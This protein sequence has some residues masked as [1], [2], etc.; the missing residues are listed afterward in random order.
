MLK[1]GVPLVQISRFVTRPYACSYL[2]RET[3]QLDYRIIAAIS[4]SAYADLLARGWRRFGM[5]F[6]RPVC[7]ACSE[8]RSLRVRVQDFHPSE[9]QRRNF[10]RNARFQTVVQPPTFTPEHLRLYN[11][12]RADMHLR[13][14]WP[15]DPMTEAEY[16]R[17]FIE[18][19]GDFAREFLLFDGR[20][21]VGVGLAD[22]VP[23]AIS[24]ITFFHDPEYRRNALGVLSL[25]RQLEFAQ[26]N[27]LAHHYL[28]YWIAGCQSMAYKSQYRPHEILA[29]YPDANDEPVWMGDHP[30]EP[31]GRT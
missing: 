23:G 20:N 28:G 17:T 25:L 29:A 18:N 24:S 5:S 15:T 13:R 30:A 27:G 3:A 12:Y 8:C 11:T 2:P 7:V 4:S 31:A 1:R 10:R 14:G 26:G 6:F 19:P 9:S 21:L 16:R 22:V